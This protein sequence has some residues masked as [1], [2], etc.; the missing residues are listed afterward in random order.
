MRWKLVPRAIYINE[1]S[2]LICLTSY[3]GVFPF[4]FVLKIIMKDYLIADTRETKRFEENRVG[5]SQHFPP[6]E[7]PSTVKLD[8]Q[9]ENIVNDISL[10]LTTGIYSYL[11]RQWGI[12]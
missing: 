9:P 7:D 2:L 11:Q 6:S 3:I 5:R 10:V 12:P 4:S 1:S 8:W